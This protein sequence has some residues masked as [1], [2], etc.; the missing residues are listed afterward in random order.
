MD[1]GSESP[2]ATDSDREGTIV[3]ASSLFV[4][5]SRLTRALNHGTT[6]RAVIPGAM[7]VTALLTDQ[8]GRS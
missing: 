5:R 1:V 2:P 7:A 8:Q 6:P 3:G 4:Q